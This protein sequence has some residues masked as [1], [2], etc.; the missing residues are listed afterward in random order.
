VR[1]KRFGRY[2]RAPVALLRSRLV[3]VDLKME[4]TICGQASNL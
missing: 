4:G 3:L 2:I 1:A